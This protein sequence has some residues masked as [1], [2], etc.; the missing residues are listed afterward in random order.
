MPEARDHVIN[1]RIRSV[2][3]RRW[4][5]LRSLSFGSVNGVIYL[6]GVLK[7]NPP[8]SCRTDANA[9]S[10]SASAGTIPR[11]TSAALGRANGSAGLA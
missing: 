3:L 11:S 10:G 1:K 8:C 2:L 7:R 5:D 9:L 6:R 4:I